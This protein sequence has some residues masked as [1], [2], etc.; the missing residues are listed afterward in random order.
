M[1]TAKGGTRGGP[2]R[3]GR[4]QGRT[5]QGRESRKRLY[6]VAIRLIAS[7]GYEATT[8]RDVAAEAGVSV[9]LLYRYFSSKRAV[10]LALYDELSAE[11]ASRA[12]RM[13]DGPWRK[14][15]IYAMRTSLETLRPHRSTLT[16]LVPLLAGNPDQGLFARATSF[17]RQRVQAVFVAAVS[18]ATDAPTMKLAAAMG[19]LL[20][21]LHL[22]VLLWWLLDKSHEQRATK[23]LV[24]ALEHALP[25]ARLILRLPPAR[26]FIIAADLAFREALLE[27]LLDSPSPIR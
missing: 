22:G 18:G 1:V 26:T 21:L 14:R 19:R 15:F 13:P 4:P 17:S 10:V 2:R 25:V 3:R 24:G 12:T 5:T 11:Y 9:G 27:D 7:H 23:A 20:Y 8:L 6:E 16:A